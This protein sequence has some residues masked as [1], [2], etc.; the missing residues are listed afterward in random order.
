MLL[1]LMMELTSLRGILPIAFCV[2]MALLGLRFLVKAY[3]F[4]KA[5]RKEAYRETLWASVA[6]F[7]LAPFVAAPQLG[8]LPATAV[9]GLVFLALRH[10]HKG[11]KR[12]TTTAVGVTLIAATSAF[13]TA[14]VAP[15]LGFGPSMW[16]TQGRDFSLTWV[17][18]RSSYET[19]DRG[20]QVYIEVPRPGSPDPETGWPAGRYHKRIVGLAG[21]TITLDKAGIIVNGKRVADC[22]LPGKS[23]PINRW[24]CDV[25][26]P[27]KKGGQQQYS[28][29]WGDPD[30]WFGPIVTWTVAD[31]QM[32][33]VGDNMTESA[34]SRDRGSVSQSWVTGHVLH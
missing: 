29:V 25:N 31:G 6:M 34:D 30:I 3:L 10:G 11:W 9:I 18:G 28:V 22:R 16:P 20:D 23:M 33:L 5:G 24:M 8:L 26:L 14:G 21:D 7:L 4:K 27:K 17:D 2:A 12:H 19:A 13:A 15:T 32:F 1:D